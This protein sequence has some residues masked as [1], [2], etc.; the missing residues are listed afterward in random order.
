MRQNPCNCRKAFFQLAWRFVH[1]VDLGFQIRRDSGRWSRVIVGNAFSRGPEWHSAR[2]LLQ[3]L[4]IKTLC[5]A[6]PEGGVSKV[7]YFVRLLSAFRHH[8]SKLRGCGVA[9]RSGGQ[10]ASDGRIRRERTSAIKTS[11]AEHRTTTHNPQ[12]TTQ[13]HSKFGS[14]RSTFWTSTFVPDTESDSASE[15]PYHLE[16]TASS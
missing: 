10:D 3:T 15:Q 12:P 7:L 2:N 13:P 1:R 11:T 8:S 4:P 16:T 6:G 5:Q 9:G 14:P